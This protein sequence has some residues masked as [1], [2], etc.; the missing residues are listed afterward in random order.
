MSG[1]R[2]PTRND[3]RRFDLIGLGEGMVELWSSEPLGR[4]GELR[5]AYG[6][7]VLNSLV[8]ASRL[9]RRVGFV[10]RVGDDPFGESLLEAWRAEGVDLASCPLV[11]GVNGV[12]FISRLPGGEREFSY[13]RSG[14]AASRLETSDVDEEYLSQ[15]RVLL[16]S[17]ITQAISATAQAASFRAAQVARELGVVVAYD[18]NYRPALWAERAKGG[19]QGMGHESPEGGHEWV[20]RRKATAAPPDGR[21]P[22]QFRPGSRESGSVGPDPQRGAELARQAFRELLPF[23]DVVLL[24]H[25]A[26]AE[27]VEPASHR[28][29]EV[30]ALLEGQ[31]PV[32]IAV[33]RGEQ[34]ALLLTGGQII[35]A[36]LNGSVRVVDTTGAGDAWN[37]GLLHALLAGWEARRALR[38]ANNVA[39]WKIGR[40]GAIPAV[41]GELPTLP[42]EGETV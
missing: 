21:E 38:F 8:M 6:G 24:S 41:D 15:S 37:A 30:A 5:R 1:F 35:E 22:G 33:K 4:A 20:G 14:S 27:L 2:L 23:V 42:R 7:D 17:G 34:G 40:F 31:G 3:G 18:P 28:A 25:P 12:Y 11:P 39:G 36:P 16:L 9:G 26:D 10:S 29:P 13:R 19:K 32:M